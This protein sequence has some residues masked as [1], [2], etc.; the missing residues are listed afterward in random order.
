MPGGLILLIAFL[1]TRVQ[2]AGVLPGLVRIFP[3]IVLGAGLF[4]GWRFNRIQLIFVILILALT[5]RSLLQF[6]AGDAASEDLGHSVYNIISFLLPLNFVV[7]SMMKEQKLLTLYGLKRFSLILFQAV[8]VIVICSYPQMGL[9]V[10][11]G[12]SF[13]SWPFLSSIPLA[14][15]ALLAFGIA[16]I[17]LIVKYIQ[18][19]SVI[20]CGLIW[21]L[22]SG[23]FALTMDKIGP[24]STIYFATAGLVL[25]IS[26]IETAYGRA[27]R[28]ELTGLPARRA[29]NE[30]LSKIGKLYTVAM[31]DIDFFKKFNDKYGHHVGD[32]VLRMISSRLTSITGGGRAYRYGGEEFAV[33]FPDKSVEEALPHLEELRKVIE[34][35][36][37][38]IRYRERRRDITK[39]PKQIKRSR[40]TSVTISIGVAGRDA[41]YS[42]PSQIINAADNALYRAKRDGRNRISD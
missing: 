14:Q 29:L 2:L 21:G 4:V 10:Y 22:V 17:I 6:A 39:N 15:P 16:A 1:L 19:R 31:V 18:H 23:F 37:F 42:N 36:G 9:A 28:D 32:D 13:F 20:D 34:E 26:V 7:F 30:T 3:L 11:L 24:S 27:F 5:D 40:Q 41:R 35:S 25:I 8:G 38:V 33:V 12:H